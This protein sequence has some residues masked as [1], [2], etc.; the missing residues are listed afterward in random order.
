MDILKF[1]TKE[2]LSDADI[3]EGIT[4]KMWVERYR[5]AGE[6]RIIAPVDSGVREQ[7]TVG[8]FISHINSTDLM[9]VENH[10]ISSTSGESPDVIITGR[11]FETLLEN[12]IVGSNKTIPTLG[13]F[14]DFYCPSSQ[15]WSAAIQVMRDLVLLNTKGGGLLDTTNEFRYVYPT[16]IGTPA[17]DVGDIWVKAGKNAYQAIMELL[18]IADTGIKAIRPGPWSTI[19]YGTT[20]DINLVV[21]QGIDRSDT[22]TFSW[23]AGEVLSADYLWTN[24]AQKT[25]AYIRGKW[26]D[27]WVV[28]S[29]TSDRF[30]RRI[31]FID[32]T[33]FDNNWN[34]A[35]TTTEQTTIRTQMS[36]YALNTLRAQKFLTLVK[37][38]ISQTGTAF[39]YRT[40]YD[41]G[42]IVT[43]NGEYGSG[44]MRV[45]EYIEYE[46]ETGANGYPTVS[47]LT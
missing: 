36:Q 19:N 47:V 10:E 1:K 33:D 5:D 16:W 9:I 25:A 2:P 21:H 31:M 7:L 43:V 15:P 35:P 3:V 11:G 18:L 13:P 28:L 12:R 22:I 37:A 44:E 39:K 32:G 8:S 41:L 23:D 45:T 34:T 30:D 42:D 14:N 27:A 20:T 26:C 24:K 38:D 4:S 40:D 46:D 6:F 29:G 17:G